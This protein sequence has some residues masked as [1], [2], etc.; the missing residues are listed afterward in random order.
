[1]A[2]FSIDLVPVLVAGL[3]AF[4]IGGIW[5][6]PLFGRAW[7]Q[8]VGV[9]PETINPAVYGIGFVC[10]VLL[11]GAVSAVV[12][13]SAVSTVLDGLIVGAVLW[14]GIAVALGVNAT[15]FSARSRTALW[16]DGLF[17]LVA[18]L[19]VGGILGAWA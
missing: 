9:D 18:F 8:A 5:Y 10:Y 11:A 1:M 17:Q 14:A 19:A 12:N 6:G 15:L 2:S 13:W 4:I 7:S 16:I 3:A